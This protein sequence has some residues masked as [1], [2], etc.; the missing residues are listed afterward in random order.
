MKNILKKIIIENQERIIKIKVVERQIDFELEANYIITG[1]RRTGKTYLL[2]RQIQQLIEKGI[3]EKEILYINFEDERLLEFKT[4]DFD[5]ILES[6]Y[7]LYDLKPVIFFDEIQNIP[8]WQK[9]ARRLAD[10][11]FKIW[12]TGSNAQ[13][14]SNEMATTLGGRFMV[15]EIDSLSFEEYLSFY[16]IATESNMVYAEKRFEIQHKFEDYFYFGGFPEI[17]KYSN[18][19]EYLNNIFQ[20]IFLGDIIARHQVRNTHALRLMIKKLAES[21]MDEVSFNRVK[22]IIKSTG[23]MVGT[24]TVTEYFAYIEDAFLIA[25]LQNFRT[26]ITER[27]SKKKYYF[28]D[29][30]L[31][32]LFLTEAES[33]LMETIVFNHLRKKYPANLYYLKEV[34]EVDFLI[35][36]K[37]LIQVAYSLADIKTKERE[38]SALIKAA[39][40]YNIHNLVIITYNQ[41]E[42]IQNE[43]KQISVV[44]IWK[45][46]LNLI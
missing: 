44:P 39:K 33:F 10:S 23:I 2:Y 41:E 22:N 7:E 34:Y 24:S 46:L 17:Q 3:S 28:R 45:Y 37:M 9:Y 18:K 38:I 35:A 11:N 6:Y 15:K 13:M 26:K 29:H 30:G 14:L 5:N 36:D 40:T 32:S 21:T 25:G 42:I 1:Q 8:N 27:E 20:K 12:I 31:L 19:R 4:S 43:G 16:Q